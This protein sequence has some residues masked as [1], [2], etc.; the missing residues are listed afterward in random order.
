MTFHE[1]GIYKIFHEIYINFRE[2]EFFIEPGKCSV[3]N[4]FDSVA[5]F[6][7][8]QQCTNRSKRQIR[9]MS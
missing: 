4:V 6:I 9:A 8:I 1:Y 2:F 5:D 3:Q 7:R